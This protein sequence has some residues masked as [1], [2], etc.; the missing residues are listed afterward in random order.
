MKETGNL[1]EV[2][3]SFINRIKQRISAVN[4]P[5]HAAVVQLRPLLAQPSVDVILISHPELRFTSK[6][7]KYQKQN[8]QMT[9][10]KKNKQTNKQN[11]HNKT[12]QHKTNETT[13]K[14]N[15]PSVRGPRAETRL[16]VYR[17]LYIRMLSQLVGFG[18]VERAIITRTEGISVRVIRML[19][20][21]VGFGP[22]EQLN[23]KSDVFF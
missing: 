19:S 2:K 5:N 8:G 10:R 7:N 16:T 17:S 12:K 4:H 9:K 20:Q 1:Q 6:S 3:S 15:K 23:V 14:K 18:P 22:V 11:K 21:L 13:N